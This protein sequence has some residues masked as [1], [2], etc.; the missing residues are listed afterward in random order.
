MQN[1][2]DLNNIVLIYLAVHL[3]ITWCFFL[4]GPINKVTLCCFPFWP[5][6][7]EDKHMD[8]IFS[9]I[10]YKHVY[11]FVFHLFCH[12]LFCPSRV[13]CVVV[14]AL[15]LFPPPRYSCDHSQYNTISNARRLKF[16]SGIHRRTGAL[17]GRLMWLAH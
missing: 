3:N 1:D 10:S 4:F 15:V 13:N 14:C 9:I 5:H 17:L 11:I 6:K 2:Y 12:T 16:Q 8:M 7:V